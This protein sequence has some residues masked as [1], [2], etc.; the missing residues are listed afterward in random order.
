MLSIKF[1]IRTNSNSGIENDDLFIDID[2]NKTQKYNNITI[3]HSKIN[4]MWMRL[5]V[6]KYFVTAEWFHKLMTK[7][8]LLSSLSNNLKN[9]EYHHE[10]HWS[11][12]DYKE[13][14]KSKYTGEKWILWKIWLSNN[15]FPELFLLKD[16][17][18]VNF[19]KDQFTFSIEIEIHK[20]IF[21]INWKWIKTIDNTWNHQEKIS[22]VIVNEFNI[23]TEN[24]FSDEIKR[25]IE[26][27]INYYICNL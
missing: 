2:I 5:E 18:E 3:K 7:I 1:T 27:Y 6:L 25:Q 4:T 14:E 8:F 11:L 23:T 13:K 24:N 21:V 12:K 19:I 16:N 9:T 20:K 17:C 22:N 15:H 26:R 10:K